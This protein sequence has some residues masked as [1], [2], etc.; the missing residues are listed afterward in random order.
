MSAHKNL[1]LMILFKKW[2]KNNKTTWQQLILVYLINSQS[3]LIFLLAYSLSLK[4]VYVKENVSS[5]ELSQVFIS[6][7]ID[8]LMQLKALILKLVKWSW[9]STFSFFTTWID[10]RSSQECVIKSACCNFKLRFTIN[11]NKY[12]MTFMHFT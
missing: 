12:Q 2:T 3:Y 9:S 7:C 8:H 4:N 11:H 10:V 5:K 6:V 1:F